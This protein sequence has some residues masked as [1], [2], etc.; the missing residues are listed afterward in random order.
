LQLE[1][2]SVGA[3]SIGLATAKL[4]FGCE[5]QS[6]AYD[7]WKYE[8]L[9]EALPAK[10]FDSAV[11]QPWYL[12]PVGSRRPGGERLVKLHHQLERLQQAVH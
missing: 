4:F 5:A 8:F 3:C 1:V 6:A 2:V 11:C 7:N 9:Q 12:G 10:R